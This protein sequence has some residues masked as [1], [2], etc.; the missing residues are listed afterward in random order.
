MAQVASAPSSASQPSAPFCVDRLEVTN[1]DY[2]A[3]LAA[4][5]DGCPAS[6][7]PR[8]SSTTNAAR[9]TVIVDAESDERPTACFRRDAAPAPAPG[10][11]LPVVCID[12]CGAA[13]YCASKGKHLCTGEW[14]AACSGAGTREAP[15]GPAA[16]D[17]CACNVAGMTGQLVTCAGFAAGEKMLASTEPS[18]CDTPEG[19]RNLFGN[20]AEWTDD[21]VIGGGDGRA[22][23]CTVRG[24]SFVDDNDFG[25]CLYRESLARGKARTDLGFRCCGG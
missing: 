8:C 3:F 4:C 25:T 13:V 7:P 16:D 15:Y 24:A 2:D 22:D 6:R 18:S 11:T 21:C 17:P 20:A 12:W 23:S 9:H 5:P 14:A 19:V 10:P 1:A